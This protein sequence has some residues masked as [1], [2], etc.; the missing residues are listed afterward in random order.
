MLNFHIITIFPDSIECYFKSS[1]LKRAIED[2]KISVNFYN[3]RDFTKNKHNRVDNK[4]YGGGPGMVL[5]A[6]SFLRAADKAIG[7]K[8]NVEVIFFS[9]GGEQFD[10]KMAGGFLQQKSKAVSNKHIIFL[11][12]RYEGV[13]ARVPQILKAR[14]VSVG[15][16][17]LTGGELPAAIMI[18]VVSRLIPGVLGN[19]NS[20]EEKRKTNHKQENSDS[21]ASHEMYT[22][23][24]TLVWK[25]K[26]YKVPEILL[27]GNHEK[28]EKWKKG[29]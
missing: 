5:E 1:M 13:D 28:I 26:K 23:P 15:P 20:I 8:K 7:K 6:E 29:R 18:D 11:C 25:R 27:S 9:P 12:G 19:A 21:V 10:Q 4:P 3:P 24:E 22:R 16:Y 14:S 2:M 17:V